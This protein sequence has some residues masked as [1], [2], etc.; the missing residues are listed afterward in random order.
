MVRINGLYNP[1]E[2]PIYKQVIT[3][4][5]TIDPNFLGHTSRYLF[6][7]A[8]HYELRFASYDAWNKSPKNT[9][10]KWWCQN[11]ALPWYTPNMATAKMAFLKRKVILQPSITKVL[12]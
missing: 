7:S 5:L 6:P 10:P 9:L 3:H 2:Y 1:K 4:L 11:G 12:C 8:T